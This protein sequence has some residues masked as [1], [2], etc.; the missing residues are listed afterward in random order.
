[1]TIWVDVDG[2]KRLVRIPIANQKVCVHD[3]PLYDECE[4]CLDYRRKVDQFI[5]SQQAPITISDQGGE[6]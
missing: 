5:A 1:M 6:G 2:M 3:M 4:H